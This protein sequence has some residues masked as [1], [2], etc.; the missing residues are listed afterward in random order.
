M[1][2]ED[3]HANET[4]TGTASTGPASASPAAAYPATAYP[5]TAHQ[6]D[7]DEFSTAEFGSD[8]TADPAPDRWY[9][10]ATAGLVSGYLPTVERDPS[11]DTRPHQ[12]VPATE[13]SDS[14]SVREAM[15]AVLAAEDDQ[16]GPQQRRGSPRS[17]GWARR[18]SAQPGRLPVNRREPGAARGQKP[19]DWPK[20][21]TINRPFQSGNSQTKRAQQALVIVLVLILVVVFFNVISALF[22]WLN[23]AFH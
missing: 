13:T 6:T 17:S 19:R 14:E 8:G 21:P 2:G 11:E 7:P 3:D 12:R 16:N 10:D 5:A 15:E 9:P 20:R 22:Q 4:S 23:G 1:A 18:E